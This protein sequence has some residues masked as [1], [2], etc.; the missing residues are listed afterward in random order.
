[1]RIT[2]ILTIIA[3]LFTLT[4]AIAQRKMTTIMEAIGQ[5]EGERVTIEMD[6]TTIMAQRNNDSYFPAAVMTDNGLTFKAEVRPRGK[7]RR[8]NAVYPPLKLKFKKK[9]L[10]AAGMDTLNEIKLVLPAFDNS[11]GDELVIR[12]YLAYKMFEKLSPVHVKARLIRLTIKDTHVEKSKKNMFA[13]L[14]ED[15]EE[16]AARYNGVEVEEYG[17]S[18]DS[19][20]ANQAALM[21][22]FEYMIGNTDWDISMM[23]NVRLLRTQAGGKILSLPYDFDFSGLVSAPYASPSSDTGLKTVRDRFLMANGIKPDALKRA[24]MNIRKNRQA[25]YD[26][27][28]NRFVSRETSDDMML[29][30]DTFFNQIGENDEVPQML[31]MSEA[32]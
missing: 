21:V 15:A 29:F 22:M 6:L 14:V 8:K 12:E 17:I 18:P 27:C 24:V 28:R 26:I 11:M 4:S 20:A 16:T 5:N 23:R 2:S 19:L 31:K 25:L 9:E 13:I 32:D 7:Y 3:F 10:I 30:L 1:M